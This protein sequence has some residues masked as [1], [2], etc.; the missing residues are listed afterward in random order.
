M[1]TK[2][3]IFTEQEAYLKLS[4]LCA[5]AEYC[6]YD[7]HR[8]ARNWEIVTN[9]KVADVSSPENRLLGVISRLREERFIDDERYARA[10]VRDKFRYNHWGRVRIIQEL[11]I[12]KIDSSIIADAIEEIPEDDNLDTLRRLIETKRKSVKGKSDYDV[13]CKLIRFAL[14]RGFGMDDIIRVLGD[15]D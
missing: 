2:K 6:E 5:S 7:L 10:F 13:R 9:E 15:A 1:N 14:G 11:R 4:A 3:H 8:K 12:R